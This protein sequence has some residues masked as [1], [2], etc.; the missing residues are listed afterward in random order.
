MLLAPWTNIKQF[1]LDLPPHV[2]AGA[3]NAI[4]PLLAQNRNPELRIHALDYSSHAV[5]LVQVLFNRSCCF[6]PLL[7]S[8]LIQQNALYT[9]PPCGTI[10]ADV[11]DLSSA[12]PPPGLAPRSADI[13]VL[14]FVLSALHPSEWP[15]AISNIAQ[16]WKAFLFSSLPPLHHLEAP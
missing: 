14:V 9:S 8:L 13:L 7:T 16:V 12:S 3:G 15:R 6:S 4:F 2:C 5:K 1:V 10:T 11:W